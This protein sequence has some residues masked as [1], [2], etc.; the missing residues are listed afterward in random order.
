MKGCPLSCE[1]CAN[2]ESWSSK[3]QIMFS[4][5]GCKYT[6]GCKICK[7][8][9]P[10]EAINFEDEVKLNFE[11][12]KNCTSFACANVCY[13]HALKICGK[14]YGIKELIKVLNRDSHSWS[15]E[16][17][18]TFSGGEPFVQTEFLIE[19]LKE[20]KRNYFHTAI[21]TTAYMDTDTFLEGMKYIDFAFIDVK[22]M[23]REKHKEKTGVYND[24][25]L[26]NI[27]ALVHYNWQGRLVLRMP[28]IREY[29]DTYE[30][31]I[32]MIQFMKKTI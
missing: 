29:N 5:T 7:D 27:Q 25:I 17:G 13:Y 31:I 6:R 23:N 21:E 8:I 11:I 12:C 18:V 3:K 15:K 4:E 22:Q 30:N 20:C 26:K 28:V 19:A 2:P 1:W 9:C 16:G 10:Y 32:D 24:L 14:E